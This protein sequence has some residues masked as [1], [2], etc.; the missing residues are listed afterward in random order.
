MWTRFKVSTQTRW[1]P[2]TFTN[3]PKEPYRH[4]RTHCNENSTMILPNFRAHLC[5]LAGLLELPLQ[6]VQTI[7]PSDLKLPFRD[8]IC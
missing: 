7:L 3:I 2:D 4:K 5:I 1:T 6:G 8:F